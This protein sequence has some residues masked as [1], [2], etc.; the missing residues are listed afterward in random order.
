MKNIV[1]IISILLLFQTG[2]YSQPCLPQGITF[3]SQTQ[4]DNFQINYPNCTEIEGNVVIGGWSTSGITNLNGLE[5]ITSIGGGLRIFKVDSLINLSGLEN[6]GYIGGD[7]SI[8]RNDNLIS[9][10]GLN[11]LVSIGGDLSIGD[12]EYNLYT[13]LASISALNNLT[14]IGG[15]LYIWYNSSLSNL[16]G[17]DN[18]T[19]LGGDL[20]ICGNSALQNITALGNINTV[21]GCT[22]DQKKGCKD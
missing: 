16:T 15:G 22:T 3:T 9:L 2:I 5:V 18:L 8:Y 21:H 19:S 7:L 14:S 12:Y 4:I 10:E 13:S 1:T 20:K 17:L 6:L 11:S